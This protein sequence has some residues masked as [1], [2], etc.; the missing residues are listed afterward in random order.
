M[1]RRRVRSCVVSVSILG[2]RPVEI[3]G[4][5]PTLKG[6]IK[7]FYRTRTIKVITDFS[8]DQRAKETIPHTPIA[9]VRY[10]SRA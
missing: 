1:S 3:S 10:R 8:G 9:P 2:I 5:G 6:L 4:G 7:V